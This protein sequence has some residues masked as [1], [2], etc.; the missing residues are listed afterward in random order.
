MSDL[1]ELEAAVLRELFSGES[2]CLSALRAQVDAATV[3]ARTMT[4]VGFFLE[5]AIPEHIP[6]AAI[7]RRELRFGDV[8]ATIPGLEHGAGFLVLIQNGKLRE[9]EGYTYDEPWPAFVD[10]FALS[11]TDIDRKS[12]LS[13][14]AK[15]S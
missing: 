6:A 1:T 14:F 15:D 13:L 2:P 9:L 4:G 12:V 3:V 11:Y 10:K 7:A 8:Q 5:F